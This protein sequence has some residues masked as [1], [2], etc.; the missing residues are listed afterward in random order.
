MRNFKNYSTTT[1]KIFFLFLLL[2]FS[3]L[4][5]AQ[6]KS[7]KDTITAEAASKKIGEEVIIKANVVTV[8]YAK[9]S[10]GKPTFLN[11]NQPF[12]NNPIA[13]IIFENDLKKLNLNA[14]Q[15]LGKKIIVK[16]NVHYYKD[17]E[18]PYKNK[19]SITIYNKEQLVI[20]PNK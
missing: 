8:F 2:M 3:S 10:T 5:F 16:G 11:L 12:P 20:L 17:E 9:S 1:K 7:A 13:V 18:K 15:Y 19:A 6:K 4:I 14:Q